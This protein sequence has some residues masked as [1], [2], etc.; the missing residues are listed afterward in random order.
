MFCCK[1]EIHVPQEGE[2]LARTS[3]V[4]TN[5]LVWHLLELVCGEIRSVCDGPKTGDERR[6]D[7]ADGGPVDAVEEGVVLDLIDGET[8]VGGRD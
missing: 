5:G 3:G 8:T 4:G 6:L 7:V 2:I 1:A